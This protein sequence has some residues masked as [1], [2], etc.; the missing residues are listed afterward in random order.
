MTELIKKES[1]DKVLDQLSALKQENIDLKAKVKSL[2]A[3]RKSLQGKVGSLK[4]KVV[5][6]PNSKKVA[7]PKLFRHV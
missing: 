5:K 2:Q 6:A 7:N 1:T 4:R 3:E